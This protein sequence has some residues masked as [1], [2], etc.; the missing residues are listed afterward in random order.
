MAYEAPRG[1]ARYAALEDKRCAD[2]VFGLVEVRAVGGVSV[3]A[4]DEPEEL[5]QQVELVGRQVVEVAA[6]RYEGLHAPRLVAALRVVELAWRR[7]EANLHVENLAQRAILHQFPHLLEVGQVSAVVGHEARHARLLGYAVDAQ[8]IFVAC[9]QRL[10]HIAGLARS[11]GHD[12]EG[13]VAR[14]RRGDVDGVDVGVVDELL[15]VGVPLAYVVALS[16]EA[17]LGGVAAHHRH[18]LRPRHLA[19]GRSRLFLRGL[20]TAYK[21]PVY[22]LHSGLKIYVNDGVR[23]FW[24]RL[25]YAKLVQ[26]EDNTKSLG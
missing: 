12:G 20:A 11:H 3:C 15:R 23:H 5:L 24:C 14:G 13:G 19:E 21:T 17:R 9:R 16:I 2:G 1:A 26:I 22:S 7:R 4:Y 6:A 10:L 8:A 25:T 18:H